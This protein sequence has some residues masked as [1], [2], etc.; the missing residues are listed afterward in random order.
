MRFVPSQHS[1]NHFPVYRDSSSW[2]LPIRFRV[3]PWAKFW[4]FRHSMERLTGYSSFGDTKNTAISSTPSYLRR[5][6]RRKKSTDFHRVD[7][8]ILG[9]HITFLT[10]F[11]QFGS[12]DHQSRMWKCMCIGL[13]SPHVEIETDDWQL[14]FSLA[15]SKWQFP[16]MQ[17]TTK[18]PLIKSAAIFQSW[19]K[20]YILFIWLCNCK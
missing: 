18:K 12:L 19:D 15:N 6:R 13:H 4:S 16:A 1:A 20:E 10:E 11:R 2:S 5:R 3:S 7:E 8:I 17:T 14:S 9:L